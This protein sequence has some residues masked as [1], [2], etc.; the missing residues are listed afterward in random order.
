[1]AWGSVS[2]DSGASVE[3]ATKS[4]SVVSPGGAVAVAGLL[5]FGGSGGKRQLEARGG[6]QDEEV[7]GTAEYTR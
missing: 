3:T 6:S 7:A 4:T 5:L 1:M 2:V